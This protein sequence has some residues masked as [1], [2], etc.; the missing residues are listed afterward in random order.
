MKFHHLQASIANNA[1][2]KPSLYMAM[3]M[4]ESLFMDIEASCGTELS[5]CPVG[6]E[7]LPS[8]LV[9]LCRAI[10]EI[11]QDNSDQLQRNRSRLDGAM[12]KLADTRKE[13]EALS[14]V[15]QQLSAK[16]AECDALEEQLEDRQE[17]ARECQA[18][19]ARCTQA[20]QTLEELKQF[21]PA[22]VQAELEGLSGQI[23]TLESTKSQLNTR[24]QQTKQTF[25]QLFKE[26]ND[27]QEIEKKSREKMGQ[28][29]EILS[30]KQSDNDHMRTEL[31][32]LEANLLALNQESLQLQKEKTDAA[33]AAAR[34]REQLACYRSG[35]LS[36]AQ[37]ELEALRKEL[38]RLEECSHT[39]AA[40][41][42]GLKSQCQQ[43]I[44][45][46]GHLNKEKDTLTERLALS[47]KNLE[48]E[49]QEKQRL[50]N[51]LSA[52]VHELEALQSEVA[53]LKQNKLPEARELQKQEQLRQEQLRD[54]LA[55]LGSQSAAYKADIEKMNTL[56]PKLEEDVKKDRVVYDALT[57]SC[58]ASSKELESLERQI[59]ELRNNKAEEKLV[60]YRKQLEENQRQLEEI[61]RECARIEQKNAQEQK[62]LEAGQNERARLQELLRR[63]ESGVEATEKQLQELRFAGTEAYIH[64]ISI[65]EDRVKLLDSV[66]GKLA[67][68]IDNMHHILGYAPVEETIS[69][70]E[71]MKH[72]LREL[73]L[74]TEDLREALVACAKSLKME[75]R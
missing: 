75:E 21:N 11:Y 28:L 43:L 60:I 32:G 72:E 35:E 1:D 39:A 14:E 46:I 22:A 57:A 25:S 13:L 12:A 7:R 62:K 45:G 29:K 16:K 30:R 36:P 55:R 73:R 44:L 33:S 3:C 47:R 67:F 6:D 66:R 5:H 26:A 41:C 65:L 8:R 63:H 48:T 58:T 2:Q 17:A 59:T 53:Q 10:N 74:R 37:A 68:A 69:L 38:A 56:L 50:S 20:R 34:L 54:E 49:K 42:E 24:L 71:Q 31:E 23:A 15:S 40:D 52:A 70:E 9:W 18:L 51:A 61:Q 4:V 27:L 19:T 64:E